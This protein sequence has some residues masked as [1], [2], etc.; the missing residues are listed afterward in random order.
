VKYLSLLPELL[1]SKK[2]KANRI[3]SMEGGLNGILEGFEMHSAGKVS[4]EKLCY[5]VGQ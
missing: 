2:I 3:K 1:S 4:A 5:Q